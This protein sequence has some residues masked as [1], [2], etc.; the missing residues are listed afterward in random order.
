MCSGVVSG[1]RKRTHWYGRQDLQSCRLA[2]RI[3]HVTMRFFVL[4]RLL[5]ALLAMVL[6]PCAPARAQQVKAAP[7]QFDF[8][9]L[10]LSWSPE[11]CHN[12]EVL[13]LSE[14]QGRRERRAQDAATECGTPHG[15]V[16]HGMWPQNFSGTWPSNCSTAPGPADYTPYLNDTPSL[17]L[18]QHEWTKH[19]TC[20]GLAADQFFATADHLFEAVKTPQLLQTVNTT[21]QL[22]PGDILGA[23]YQANPSFPQ[24]SVALS[25][26]RNYLTAVEVCLSKK[27][28]QPIACQHV[29]TCAATVVKVAPETAPQQ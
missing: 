15:F 6:L 22:K 29:H 3:Q 25:C 20:S 5:P 7:G 26:G 10:N 27:G 4:S 14:R 1:V 24:G 19:G 12:V 28:L 17:T 23:F 11:F 18:L 16:L 13:P 8:Y 2:G 21:L 9:L